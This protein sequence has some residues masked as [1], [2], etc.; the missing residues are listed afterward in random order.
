MK[1]VYTEL[2][3]SHDPQFFLVRGVVQRT[4]EQPERANRLLVQAGPANDAILVRRRLLCS[5]H[6]DVGGEFRHMVALLHGGPAGDLHVPALHIGKVVEVDLLPFEAA[7]PR[8][9]RHIGDRIIVGD[10]R[11]GSEPALSMLTR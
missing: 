11:A 1:A 4:T 9:D 8:P 7:G 5:R 3:R 10:E 6:R 2:H